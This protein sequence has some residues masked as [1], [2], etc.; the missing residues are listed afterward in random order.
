VDV[1]DAGNSLIPTLNSLGYRPQRKFTR[2]A[3]GLSRLPGDPL[4][5]LAAAGPEF[6]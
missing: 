6:G 3:L 5:V 1:L 2:M 4:R